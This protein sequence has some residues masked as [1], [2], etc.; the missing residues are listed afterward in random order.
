MRRLTSDEQAT[1]ILI[2]AFLFGGW[3]RLLPAWMAGFPVLDGG[4]FYRMILEL[5]YN[6]YAKIDFTSYNHLQIPFAYPPLGFYLADWISDLLGAPVLEVVRWLPGVLNALTVPAFYLLAKDVLK[7]RFQAALSVLFFAF[8]PH[9]TSWNSMGG[10]L[11]RSLGL[12]F[13]LPTI[14]YALR[15]FETGER[16]HILGA[17][18]FGGLTALS[19]TEA[20]IYAAALSFYFWLMKS[21]SLKGLLNGALTA[22]GVLLVGG[23]WYAAVVARHGLAPFLSIAR[24]GAHSALSVF[25]MLNVNFLTEEPYLALLAALGVLG[26]GYLLTQR[27][28]FLPLALVAVFVAQPRSAHVVGNIPLALAAGKFAAEILLPAVSAAN[29][30]KKSAPLFILLGIYAFANSLNYGMTLARRVV[31][32][33]ERAAMQWVKEN[34]PAS[35]RFA[36]V[37][38]D[39]NA[40]CDPITEWFPALSERQN[41]TTIQGTEWLLGDQFGENMAQTHR[42]QACIDEGVECFEREAAQLGKPFDYVYV[43][44]SSPTKDCGLADAHETR[45]LILTMEDSPRYAEVYRSPEVVIFEKK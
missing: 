43:S 3:F 32:A 29:V 45:A 36:V 28:Y 11:T 4:M 22:L 5:Q 9:L 19:H 14:G 27:D 40:F 42:L 20:P 23:G 16:K 6:G 8:V 41:V 2:F 30:G 31:P 13:M 25:K 33:P 12:L 18:L 34:A 44:V 1:L 10:G 24:T 26:M 7:D 37:S 35:A 17:A 21:R 15:L 39:T 38:G